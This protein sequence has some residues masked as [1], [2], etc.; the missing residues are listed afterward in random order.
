MKKLFLECKE[1]LLK[2]CKNTKYFTFSFFTD[3]M[4][5]ERLCITAAAKDDYAEVNKYL[6]DKIFP[7]KFYSKNSP[8]YCVFLEIM[9]GYRDTRTHSLLIKV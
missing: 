8:T 3:W 9:A 7:S 6:S 5:Y 1:K 4:E 2:E